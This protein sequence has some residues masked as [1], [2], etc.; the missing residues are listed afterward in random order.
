MVKDSDAQ[1]VIAGGDF[2]FSPDKKEV[3]TYQLVKEEMR[4]P[5]QHLFPIN[6]LK[7]KLATFANPRNVFKNPK[8]NPEILE[9]IFYKS[10][11]NVNATATSYRLP[12]H[13]VEWNKPI[14]SNSDI[15]IKKMSVPF[16]DHELIETTIEYC[17][18]EN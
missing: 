4:N 14:V 5:S 11:G 17:C 7:P 6:W 12:F 10:N 8:F 9:Y 3:T 1:I 13:K 16:S 15:L 2:N 18:L